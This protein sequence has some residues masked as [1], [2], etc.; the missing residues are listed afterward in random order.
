MAKTKC[1]DSICVHGSTGSGKTTLVESLSRVVRSRLGED[2][3]VRLYSANAD[4]WGVIE[5]SVK[6]GHVVPLWVPGMIVFYRLKKAQVDIPV[7]SVYVIDKITKGW[8][9]VDPDNPLSKWIPPEKQEEWEKV[10][11]VVF[12]SGTDY[13]DLIMRNALLKEAG[14]NKLMGIATQDGTNLYQDGIPKEVSED[15][16]EVTYLSA[17]QAHYGAVQN[18]IDQ[19]INQSKNIPDVYVMWTFL[20]EKGKEKDQHRS[21]FGPDVI[22]TAINAKVPSWF[23]RTLNLMADKRGIRYLWLH[24]HEKDGDI[25]MANV[26]ESKDARLPDYLKDKEANL[27]TLYEKLD[28]SVERAMEIQKGG[29]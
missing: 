9:P 22:G 16:D 25:Y 5:P 29:K 3:I 4:G 19:F 12:D 28:E 14:T 23:G 20:T 2:K 11:A 27:F 10:G 7:N 13:A 26:R 17:A 8:W 24:E 18:R 6:L 1:I 15:G 21:V